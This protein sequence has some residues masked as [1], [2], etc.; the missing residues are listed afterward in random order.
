MNR[1]A[2]IMTL[3][4]ITC[5]AGI[6]HADII[7][8]DASSFDF[9]GTQS[10][11]FENF[12]ARSAVRTLDFNGLPAT[13]S[14]SGRRPLSNEIVQQSDGYGALAYEGDQFWKVRADHMHIDFG[15]ERL[16]EFGFFYSDLEWSDLRITF[17]NAGS[18]LLSDS[19]S[20]K[21]NFFAFKAGPQEAF[22]S[23]TFDWTDDTDGV[24]FD[25]MFVKSV[26]TPGAFALLAFSGGIITHRRRR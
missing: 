19:N 18:F 10:V 26:P 1:T 11:G 16:S 4:G 25:N 2:L 14:F 22:G 17:G 7:S 23:I 6:A 21:N 8:Q 9:T 12:D 13:V 20:N 3:S 5:I 15:D 24:G